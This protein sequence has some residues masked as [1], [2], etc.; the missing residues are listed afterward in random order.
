MHAG[1]VR[2]EVDAADEVTGGETV[3]YAVRG[4][5]EDDALSGL[6]ARAF[7]HAL[8][9]VPWSDRLG[10]HSVAWVTA[11][12]GPRLVGFVNVV[13]DGGAHA[14]LLDTC[15]DP[16]LQ[17]RG[18]GRRLVREAADWARNQGCHWLHADYEPELAAFY[19][20]GCGLRPTPAGLLRLDG[21]VVPP[22]G[23]PVDR[24]RG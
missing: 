20:D 9:L 12:L 19:E 14:I 18:I 11:H 1:C 21:T 23:H 24:A 3:S 4:P 22:S 7:G 15:V 5:V 10:A 16:D 2:E 17:G 6:H 13:G 8:G